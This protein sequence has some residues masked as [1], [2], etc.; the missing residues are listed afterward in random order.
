MSFRD[1]CAFFREVLRHPRTIGAIAETSPILARAMVQAADVAHAS[2]I[3]ELG[4]GAGAITRF[5][6]ADKPAHARV[7]AIERNSEC[8][9]LLEMRFPDLHVANGCVTRLREHAAFHYFAGAN[10]I[11]S[12]LPWTNFSET[13]Q[14]DILASAA[15]LLKPGGVF[16]TVACAG[17]HLTTRGRHF[18]HL[19]EQTFSDVQTSP[20]IWR[21]LPP[22]FL[23]RC[24]TETFRAGDAEITYRPPCDALFPDARY[25]AAFSVFQTSSPS[26]DLLWDRKGILRFK[27]CVGAFQFGA[28]GPSIQRIL[29]FGRSLH[30]ARLAVAH[31][32][33]V[34]PLRH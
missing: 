24:T 7:L 29:T 16:T 10:A 5:I 4:A 34:T 33:H 17:L 1:S 9:S 13:I 22:A 27:T 6:L 31:Q 25:R 32:T 26:P 8:A 21:N 2:D 18:R 23:Y 14:R 3:I 15:N 11:I 30:A 12:A 28:L 20:W 19:L